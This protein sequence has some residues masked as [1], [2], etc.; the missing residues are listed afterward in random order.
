M[1]LSHGNES[2]DR[3]ACRFIVAVGASGVEGLNDIQALLAALPATLA[4][5]VLVVLHRPS[6]R[7]SHLC[8]VLSRA[9]AMRVLIAQEDDRFHIGTCYIGEPDEHLALAARSRVHLI[10][11]AHDRHRNRSVDL[12]F[13]SVAAHA[14]ECALGVVLSG[15]LDDGSRGLA[16]IHEEG[17]ATLVLASRHP[18]VKGMPENATTY[19]GPIDF[20]GSVGE[21]AREIERRVAPTP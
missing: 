9:S 16:A 11:G 1:A 17:G 7:I 15:S 19:D 10:E 21:I 4:A 8:E 20:I 6:D 2:S 18:A 14:Q 5:A 13:T 3:N 12:L